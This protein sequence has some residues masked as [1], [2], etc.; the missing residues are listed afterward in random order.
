MSGN[1]KI[2]FKNPFKESFRINSQDVYTWEQRNLV[3]CSN[4]NK[5]S[6]AFELETGRHKYCC[7]ICKKRII[8]H[9]KKATYITKVYGKVFDYQDKIVYSCAFHHHILKFHFKSRKMQKMSLL[10]KYN[11]TH[12]KK[13]KHTYLV[14]KAQNPKNNRIANLTFGCIP[15]GWAFIF[16]H[17]QYMQQDPACNEFMGALLPSWLIQKQ[18]LS[19][20]DFPLFIMYPQLT[21]LPI[22][23][24]LNSNFR[25]EFKKAKEKRKQLLE[26]GYKQEKILEWLTGESSTKKERK[27]IADNPKMIFLY[28]FTLSLF[29]NVDIRQYFLREFE[30]VMRNGGYWMFIESMFKKRYLKEFLDL[31][32]YFSSE[33][34]Y[35]NALIDFMKDLV[36][37]FYH[38]PS[39]FFTIVKDIFNM[40]KKLIKEIAD[41]QVPKVRSIGSFHDQLA[42]D[43]KKIK[44]KYIEIQYTNEEQKKL[45]ME[46]DTH[47]LV[48]AKSNHQLIDVGSR[49]GICVGSYADAAINKKLFIVL[50]ED[51]VE[52]KITHCLEINY[53]RRWKIVQAK[54]KYNDCP[55]EEV[56]RMLISYCKRKKILIDTYDIRMELAS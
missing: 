56:T 27:Y 48:L 29:K 39:E 53:D 28:K 32:M 31:K 54:A 6:D 8:K 26:V 49:L 55:S 15:K 40:K 42:R 30:K 18:P 9:F 23:F 2:I 43:Y 38:S 34:K 51:K 41:Y 35:A 12:N 4:C 25:N 21:S 24:A 20:S 17:L 11:V 16:E 52:D 1:E 14:R 45:E 7:P 13:T 36:T 46:T 19:L 33:K 47:K 50:V 22:E 44:E 3:F 10:Y 37:E 5:I